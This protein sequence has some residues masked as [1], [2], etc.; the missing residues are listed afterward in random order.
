[1]PDLTRLYDVVAATWPAADT[2]Q[3]GPV[4][5]R[6]GLGGGS[7]VSAATT[8]STLTDAQMTAAQ[9]AMR[10]LGQKPTFMIR[11]RD[12]AL[13]AQLDALGYTAQDWSTIYA[14]KIDVL[15]T[16][17]PPHVSTFVVWPA[18]TVQRDIWAAGGVGP[19]R[20][21]VME[22]CKTT[23]TTVLGRADDTAAGTLYTAIDGDIAM[24]HAGEALQTHRRKGLGKHM[25][26]AAAF[27]AKDQGARYM[28]LITTKANSAANPLYTSLGM[29]VVGHYHYRQLPE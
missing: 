21:A 17:R 13:D 4:T 14:C 28:T 24:V 3:I 7:R 6:N 19:E 2:Q 27:W 16:D 23:K 12:A 29:D 1:L 22:R 11:D 18:L 9:D 15:C 5:V 20:V 26:A 10:A 8:D 25:M